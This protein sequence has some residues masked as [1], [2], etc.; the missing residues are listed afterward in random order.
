DRRAHRLGAAAIRRGGTA[1]GRGTR[2]A[3]PVRQPRATA[4]R[5]GTALARP[6]GL[7]GVRGARP[8][9]RQGLP[10]T[11]REV[12]RDDDRART[13][14][15]VRRGQPSVVTAGDGLVL[16]LDQG[17]HASRAVLF[18]AAGREVAQ[19]FVPVAT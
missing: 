19:A 14:A 3:V 18:D 16:A 6:V 5:A 17:S 8:E 12:R 2:A 10:G 11:R 9:D 13:A 1:T 4:G 15:R 7:G